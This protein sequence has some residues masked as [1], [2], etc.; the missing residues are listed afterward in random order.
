[1]EFN[2]NIE[3]LKEVLKKIKD[4]RIL[5]KDDESLSAILIEVTPENTITFIAR[6]DALWSRHELTKEDFEKFEGGA[7]KNYEIISPGRI[8]ITGQKFIEIIGSYP[9]DIILKCKLKTSKTKSKGEH[10]NVKY[11]TSSKKTANTDFASFEVKH[12]DEN[13]PMVFNDEIAKFTIPASKFIDAI[14]SVAFA[15]QIQKIDEA[16][17]HLF[18]CRVE[19]YDTDIVRA[20]STNKKRICCYGDDMKEDPSHILDPTANMIEPL[21][22]NFKRTEDI[23]VHYVKKHTL[24][25]QGSQQYSIPNTL[26]PEKF[27]DCR[28]I[29]KAKM[30]ENTVK[31]KIDKQD[32][33]KC[34]KT[35]TLTAGK[36][37]GMKMDLDTE[38]QTIAF[39]A[40]KIDDGGKE[41]TLH[42]ESEPLGDAQIEL[43]NEEHLKTSVTV[44][45]AFFQDILTRFPSDYI[46]I[47]FGDADT[48]F[49]EDEEANFRYLLCLLEEED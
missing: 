49:F 1:M 35:I 34:L 36:G 45:I 47:S 46:F 41:K 14:K 24:L 40:K 3:P 6:N 39:S 7:E 13:P 37:Y 28:R 11:K 2:I 27:P 5:E 32:M 30:K 31:I 43:L 42:E 26:E 4:S 10:L 33:K 25:V 8:F 38:K 22:N 23:E 16:E 9:G 48:I 19:I 15:A 21:L 17:Q 29:L 44:N 12:F 18:G 20:I